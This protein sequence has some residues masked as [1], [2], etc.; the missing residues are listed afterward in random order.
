[1]RFIDIQK[2]QRDEDTKN[3]DNFEKLAY[4]CNTKVLSYSSGQCD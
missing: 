1:M 2:R 4:Y 3:K